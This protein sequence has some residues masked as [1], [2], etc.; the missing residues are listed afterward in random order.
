LLLIVVLVA[1][2][3]LQHIKEILSTATATTA[4]ILLEPAL[5]GKNLISKLLGIEASLLR[6]SRFLFQLNR[7]LLAVR[8]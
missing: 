7:I 8:G 5:H 2:Q 1:I 4:Y 3:H 6:L